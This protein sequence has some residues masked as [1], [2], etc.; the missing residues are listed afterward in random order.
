MFTED[1][2]MR[3]INQAIAALLNAIG[4]RKSGRYVEA[5][6]AIAQAIEH[7]TN[8]PANLVD[9]MDEGGLLALLTVQEKLDVA[10]LA[11]LADL[12]HENGL[13]LREQG[14]LA[15]GGAACA[16]ALRL[17]LEV[18]LA[19]EGDLS[20]EHLAK[21]EAWVDDLKD[22]SLP[23]DTRLAL[24]DYYHRLLDLED[25]ALAAAGLARPQIIQALAS[26]QDQLDHE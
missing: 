7:L 16:R 2:L 24:S 23:I 25:G 3:M 20:P 4:L 10:R 8:L 18:A 5:G 12:F 11:I 21:I 22:T 1:Y 19:E 14:I 17:A 6:Q 26:L 9:Q 13:I 15:P